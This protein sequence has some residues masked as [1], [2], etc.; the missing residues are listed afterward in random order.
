M[1]YLPDGTPLDIAV[2]LDLGEVDDV[3]LLAH[4]LGELRGICR[5]ILAM[6]HL[7]GGIKGIADVVLT[8]RVED[9]SHDLDA[10]CLGTENVVQESELHNDYNIKDADAGFDDPSVLEDN[11][12]G[13]EAPASSDEVDF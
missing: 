12:S 8:S 13:A 5:S 1:P 9:G 3:S 2:Q 11:N 4:D 7:A 6:P 10:A